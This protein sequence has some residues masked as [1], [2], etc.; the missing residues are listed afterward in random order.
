[1]PN[2]S[3]MHVQHLIL[4]LFDGYAIVW[5]L[6]AFLGVCGMIWGGCKLRQDFG[7]QRDHATKKRY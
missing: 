6:L 5:A 7:F 3:A 1:M 2:E 4:G